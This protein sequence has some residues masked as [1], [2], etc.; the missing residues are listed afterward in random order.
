[1]IAKPFVN[2]FDL[3]LCILQDVLNRVKKMCEEE[4]IPEWKVS[5]VITE[6]RNI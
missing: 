3:F 1:M 4:G 2:I 5:G 6:I